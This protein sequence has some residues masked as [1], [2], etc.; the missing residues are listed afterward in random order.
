[1]GGAALA[2]SLLCFGLVA[3]GEREEAEAV[4]QDLLQAAETGY[5]K[6][7]FLANAHL[8]L[9]Y[10]EEALASVEK[11]AAERDPWLIWFGT[12]PKLDALRGEPRFIQAFRTTNNPMAFV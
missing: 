2:M 9:G 1:M 7:Y 6:E 10:R 5:V 11:A 4:R 12:D 8:A 3:A